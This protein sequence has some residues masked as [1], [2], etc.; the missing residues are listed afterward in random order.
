MGIHLVQGGAVTVM[1]GDLDRA[2]RF[3][4]S[5]L[6]FELRMQRGADYAELELPGLTLGLTRAGAPAWKADHAFPISIALDVER[7][8][9]A[10]LVL[11]ERGVQF[12]PDVAE[13]EGQRIVFFTDPEGTPLYLRERPR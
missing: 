8:E 3:Y 1:V 11:R 5:A 2:V 7:L 4:T 13:R 6:G 10:M 9:G 12:A